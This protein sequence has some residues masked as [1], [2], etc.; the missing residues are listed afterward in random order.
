MKRAIALILGFSFFL[1]VMFSLLTYIKP[2]KEKLEAGIVSSGKLTEKWVRD[3]DLSLREAMYYDK[4]PKGAVKCRLCPWEC[5]IPEGERGICGVRANIGGTLRTLVYGKP[6]AVHID[7][8]E[9]KPVFH[10]LPGTKAF[11]IATA[12]CNLGCI[13]CQNWTISQIKPE[14]A[15]HYNLPPEEAVRQA[16]VAG[17]SSI[18]YTY[19]EP[20]IF[21]EYMLETAKLAHKEGLKNIWVTAGFINEEPLRELCKYIDAANIDLKGITEDYYR[22]YVKGQLAPVQKSIKIACEEGVS[23]EITNL[24]I[25]GGND[26]EKDI[27]KLCQ[28][29]YD[30]LGPDVPLHFSRF[31]PHY[32]LTDRPPTPLKTLLRAREIA[33]EV[34]IRYVYIGN[35]PGTEYETTYCPKCGKEL[36]VRRGFWIEKNLIK[37]G[38]CPYCGEKIPGV[39]E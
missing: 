27:R 32:K 17:C 31:F 15:V 10:F 16:K 22:E 39:W 25:P 19:S 6:V 38:K 20:S 30:N 35:V 18:A 12:G 4:L 23:V 3:H 14:D 28:W 34:G 29:I 8:V 21:Y 7:P 36:V 2:A 11:S 33:K 1:L 5:T 37:D 9:K 13:F 24:I 26:S